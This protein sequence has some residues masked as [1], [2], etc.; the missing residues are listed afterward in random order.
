M[1]DKYQYS[2]E[3]KDLKVHGWISTNPPIGFWQITPSDEFRSG[4]PHKQSLTSHVGPTTLAVGDL[5]PLIMEILCDNG[6]FSFNFNFPFQI[7]LSTHYAGQDLVPKFRNGEPW[8]KVFGPVFLYLNSTKAGDDPFWLWEDAKIQV[9]CIKTLIFCVCMDD[10]FIR[11]TNNH[12][13]L[14]D[15]DRSPKLAIQFPRLRRFPETG[16]TGYH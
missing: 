10:T 2:C 3:N 15:D 11:Y 1:D 5:I 7:F 8:K 9:C 12:M 4:G 6:I 13:I 16:S 14:P